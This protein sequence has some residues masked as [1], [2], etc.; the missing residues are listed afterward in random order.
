MFTFFSQLTLFIAAG[1]AFVQSKDNI[2]IIDA[3]SS[4]TA[5]LQSFC[6]SLFNSGYVTSEKTSS[7][8][9]DWLGGAMQQADLSTFHVR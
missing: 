9:D 8:A 3:K 6:W 7:E 1:W 5:C 2:K 4:F